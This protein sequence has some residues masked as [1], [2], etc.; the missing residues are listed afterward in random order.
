MKIAFNFT[1]ADPALINGFKVKLQQTTLTQITG[2]TS[3]GWT[4]CYDGTFTVPG[5]GYQSI[6]LTTPFLWNGHTNLLMEICY[7]NSSYTQYSPVLAHSAPG[8]FWGK[9]QDL[10]SG[11]GC[12]NETWT[13]TVLPPGR[14]NTC[15][16]ISLDP[17]GIR[18]IGNYIPN[19]YSLSQNYPNPFNPVTQIKF[20]IA[21]QGLT[22]LKIFDVLGREIMT[23]VNEV[24]TPGSYIVDFDGSNIASGVYFYRL[25]S[26]TFTDVK[27]MILI[28]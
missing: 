10:S 23:L 19:A 11:D 13:S 25:E 26:G 5:T 4:T 15:F 27:R 3:T 14:P 8:M 2:F 24:K 9:Y 22:K 28:K 16:I 7:N 12:T 20:D 1:A 17:I 6:T 21:K 18:N